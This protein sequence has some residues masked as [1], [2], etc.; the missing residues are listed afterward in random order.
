MSPR[1]WR[2]INEPE[3][4][5]PPAALAR[6]CSNRTARALAAAD[7]LIRRKHDG[8]YLA[9]VRRLGRGWR[10]EALAPPGTRAGLAG[11]AERLTD[12]E[13]AGATLPLDCLPALLAE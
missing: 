3:F 11:L 12:R 1:H 7:W 4:E 5:A 10:L 8:R 9:A 2:L 13:R 6:A